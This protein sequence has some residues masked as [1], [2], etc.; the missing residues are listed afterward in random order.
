[1]SIR[2]YSSPCKQLQDNTGIERSDGSAR[3]LNGCSCKRVG[4]GAHISL[5]NIPHYNTM[6]I[7][8]TKNRM[9]REA[10][11][12]EI[13]IRRYCRDH[14]ASATLCDTCRQLLDYARKRLSHCPFQ[15]QK[16]TCGKCPV[17]CY[18]PAK[19]EQIRAVMRHAGPRLLRSHPLLAIL[20]L[21]DGLRP[22][23]RKGPPRAA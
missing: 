13:M 7:L 18:A 16:P 2:Q 6:G 19:R 20:H 5:R 17:H 21:L 10:R 4:H 15:E 8:S 23:G 12:V 3:H 14:H 1:M 11:T 9:R 22:P